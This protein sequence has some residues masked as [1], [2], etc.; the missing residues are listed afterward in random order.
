MYCSYKDSPSLFMMS[1][2]EWQDM[3]K[4]NG[5]DVTVSCISD[6][7]EG[8]P[9]MMCREAWITLDEVRQSPCL[10]CPGVLLC[11]GRCNRA[12]SFDRDHLHTLSS[13]QTPVG[14]IDSFE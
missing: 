6:L 3:L 7:K 10:S 11:D 2:V 1:C 5:M 14:F 9:W 4:E 8:K 13:P 12:K